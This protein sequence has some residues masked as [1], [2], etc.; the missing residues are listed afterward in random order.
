[1]P[2]ATLKLPIAAVT[3][4]PHRPPMILVDQLVEFADDSGVVTASIQQDNIFV[5][6]TGLM[7]SAAVIELVAQAY[8]TIKGC[9]DT[10]KKIP[11]RR[12]FLVGGRG[13]KIY[14]CPQ[15]GDRL[16][17]AIETAAELDE[18]SVISGVITCAEEVIAEGSVKLWIP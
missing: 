12:G 5:D 14:R 2:S 10:I 18:F 1:M 15:V 11:V 6:G 4:L 8:A 7:E 13:F 9:N 16:S 17:I 3:L